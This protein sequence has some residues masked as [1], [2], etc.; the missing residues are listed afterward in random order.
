LCYLF[1]ALNARGDGIISSEEFAAATALLAAKGGEGAHLASHLQDAWHSRGPEEQSLTWEQWQ[2][3]SQ[4]AA[5]NYA[6]PSP[7]RLHEMQH[8]I[9]DV[10]MARQQMAASYRQVPRMRSRTPQSREPSVEAQRA[11]NV[12]SILQYGGRAMTPTR[13][14]PIGGPGRARS[15]SEWQL[16]PAA[17]LGLPPA[18][19]HS[20]PPLLPTKSRSLAEGQL[21]AAGRHT[22]SRALRRSR[23]SMKLQ[24]GWEHAVDVTEA[25]IATPRRCLSTAAERANSA[26]EELAGGLTPSRRGSWHMQEPYPSAVMA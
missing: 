21:E 2:A 17:K 1:R 25:I 20:K 9:A 14:L 6:A 24:T 4:A 15:M 10:A 16:P 18:M 3:H 13:A 5:S 11:Q 12:G 22:P 19:P 8:T 26:L 23:T 7:Q